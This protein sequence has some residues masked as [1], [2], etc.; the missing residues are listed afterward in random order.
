MGGSTQAVAI[1]VPKRSW[2]DCRMSSTRTFTV[3]ALD[4]PEQMRELLESLANDDESD[5]RM[6]LDLDISHIDL[7]AQVELAKYS[8]DGPAR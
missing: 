7:R 4:T 2:F 8:M 6:A 3:A 1:P 5:F